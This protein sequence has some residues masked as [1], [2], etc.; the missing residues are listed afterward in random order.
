MSK[1]GIKIKAKYDDE[2]KEYY[3]WKKTGDNS[4]IIVPKQNVEKDGSHITIHPSGIINVHSKSK[5]FYNLLNNP[6]LKDF[7]QKTISELKIIKNP[8]CA[9]ILNLNDTKKYIHK[10]QK[11]HL[12][13]MDSYSENCETIEIKNN[14]FSFVQ[15]HKNPFEEVIIITKDGKTYFAAKNKPGYGILID[16]N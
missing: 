10:N 8:L 3:R 4:Q 11:E 13:D 7:V 15:N 12:Y 5:K 14:D 9:I 2:I 6:E 16:V 1:K